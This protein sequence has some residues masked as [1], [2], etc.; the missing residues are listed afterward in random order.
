[1]FYLYIFISPTLIWRL[2][3]A[4]NCNCKLLSC[5]YF[6]GK[7]IWSKVWISAIG[8]RGVIY[9]IVLLPSH[10]TKTNDYKTGSAL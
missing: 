2:F 8:M 3:T 5:A 10:L 9:F 1:M 7:F 4:V 6:Y